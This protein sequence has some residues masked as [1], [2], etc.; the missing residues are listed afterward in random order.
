M[1]GMRAKGGL[2]LGVVLAS[3][4]AL[5]PATRAWWAGESQTGQGLRLG[6]DLQGGMLLDL[7]VDSQNALE[8]M[9]DEQAE[10]TENLLLDELINYLS[11]TRTPKGI[12]VLLAEGEKVAWNEAPFRRLLVPWEVAP[13]EENGWLLRL[14]EGEAQEMRRRAVEQAQEVLRNRIDALGVS[15]PSIQ[16]QGLNGLLI[17]L[18]GL[19][20][21][22]AALRT[23]GTQAVLE[24]YLV[25]DDHTPAS[26]QPNLHV[27]KYARTLGEQDPSLGEAYVLERRPVLSGERV[28]DAR[29][30]IS[31]YDNSSYVSL[32]FDSLGSDRFARITSTNQG[33]RL[34]IVLDGKVQSAPVIREAITGGEAQISGGFQT[35]EARELALVLRSGALPAPLN[36]RE[37]R[38]VGASLGDDS[39][40]WGLF[41]LLGGIV[42]VMFFMIAYYRTAGVF[43]CIALLLNLLIILGILNWIQATLTLPGITGIVLTIGIAVDANVLIFERIREQ[44]REGSGYHVAVREGFKRA[45]WTIFDANVTTLVAAAALLMYGSGPIKGFAVTLTI[46][47]LTS[48]FTAIFVSHYLFDLMA[49]RNQ[50][51]VRLGASL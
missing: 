42:L 40:R 48:M 24:F 3:M 14:P 43:A 41:S 11:V 13:L 27:I 15:E 38:T 16:R 34:A 44:L 28:R 26:A 36:V 8:R 1:G 33:R 32:R 20:D 2:I 50:G 39:V 19:R 21:R 46:G 10:E 45:F 37:E 35:K 7:E 6:L 12:E 4:I 18:P 9:Q 29:V 25:V 5:W 22:E 17:Q 23:L 49:R 51:K 30:Q 47:I 31:S